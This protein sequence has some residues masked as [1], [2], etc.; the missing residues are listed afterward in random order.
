MGI[1]P[2]LTSPVPRI[3]DAGYA[4]LRDSV[5]Q[6]GEMHQGPGIYLL[7]VPSEVRV[8]VQDDPH[9][10]FSVAQPSGYTT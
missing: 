1:Y 7:R 8:L 9:V 6:S 3:A 10:H 5:H 4:H 2:E